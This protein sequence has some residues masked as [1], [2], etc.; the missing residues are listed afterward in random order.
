MIKT[1]EMAAGLK[2]IL[3]LEREPVGV[4]FLKENDRRSLKDTYD[5]ETKT[6]YCQALMRAGNGKKIMVTGENIS[7]PASAAAFGLKPLTEMLSIRE[8]AL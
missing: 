2:N 7:C 1:A 5:G 3:N 4:K 6:R 8:N